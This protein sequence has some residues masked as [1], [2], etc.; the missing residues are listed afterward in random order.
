MQKNTNFEGLFSCEHA[1]QNLINAAKTHLTKDVYL[2]NF[3]L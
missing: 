1:K 2:Q 3:L